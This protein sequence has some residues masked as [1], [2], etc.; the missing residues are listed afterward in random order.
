MQKEKHLDP[1]FPALTPAQR[2]HIEVNGYVVIENL[3]SPERTGL[4]LESLQSLKSQFMAQED[5]WNTT[6]GNCGIFG[7]QLL[8]QHVHF[9]HLLEVNSE[10][11]KYATDS[12][13]V[14]MAEEV[15][16]KVVRVV[17][18]EAAI[19]R[20]DPGDKYDGALRHNWH[21]ARPE[22]ITY[23]D[24]GLLHCEFVKAITNLT[25]LGPDDGGTCVIAGSHKSSCPEEDI[26]KA[27]RE[28][29]SLIHRFIAPA[30]STLIFCETLLH[31][32]GDLRS[33]RERAI[34]ITGYK[35]RSSRPNIGIPF[36]PDFEDRVPESH[37]VLIFGTDTTRVRRRNLGMAVGSADPGEYYD[38]WSLNSEDPDAYEVAEL[39]KSRTV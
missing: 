8:G 19:N 34:I 6:I 28:D 13:I 21:R 37:K 1:P 39:T 12:R 29:P 38:G 26:V 15:V 23:Y 4:M 9:H 10:F 22:A 17:E 25:D 3:F 20:R 2:W 7:K 33:D 24:K 18:T 27:A 32:T 30:G 11:F 5:P 35:P 14:G 31:A 16:G 36:G